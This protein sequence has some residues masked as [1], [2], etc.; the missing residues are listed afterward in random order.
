MSV[1]LNPFQENLFH[2]LRGCA[3]L[4]TT[5]TIKSIPQPHSASDNHH[6]LSCQIGEGNSSAFFY[7]TLPLYAYQVFIMISDTFDEAYYE[8]LATLDAE[9]ESKDIIRLGSVTKLQQPFFNKKGWL[10]AFMT[11]GKLL[12]NDFPTK[13][14]VDNEELTFLLVQLIDDKEYQLSQQHDANF[15]I[16]KILKSRNLIAL[17]SIKKSQEKPTAKPP[18]NPT[19]HSIVFQEKAENKPPKENEKPAIKK[20]FSLKKN[21]TNL[22]FSNFWLYLEI[23][24]GIVL[25]SSSIFLSLNSLAMTNQWAIIL[26]ILLAGIGLISL[27][28][29]NKEYK[30][31]KEID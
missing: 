8:L 14:I 19:S 30:S 3:P 6:V 9:S 22:S 15:F 24:M 17:D 21:T 12:I 10:G 31:L 18:K 7:M 11:E 20:N 29:A 28:S 13:A 26:P 16:E 23:L 5:A 2:F 1:I 4:G 27:I 25:L